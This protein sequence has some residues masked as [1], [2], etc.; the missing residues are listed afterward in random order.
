M[1]YQ[2]ATT[3]RNTLPSYLTTNQ[4]FDNTVIV[5]VPGQTNSPL[6]MNQQMD[7]SLGSDNY[8]CFLGLPTEITEQ[9][10]LD[11][12]RAQKYELPIEVEEVHE[13]VMTYLRL[14]FKSEQTVRDLVFQDVYVGPT[15][16]NLIFPVLVLPLVGDKKVDE[17]LVHHQVQVESSIPVDALF[18]GL[19][20]DPYGMMVDCIDMKP[21]R[22]V[23][24]FSKQR[25][26][27]RVLAIPNISLQKGDIEI[28]M[29]HRL[30]D[31]CYP[32]LR[33]NL[34]SQ[35]QS[36]LSRYIKDIY[37]EN[38]SLSPNKEQPAAKS[39]EFIE[40]VKEAEEAAITL[41]QPVSE[42]NDSIAGKRYDKNKGA[43]N[44]LFHMRWR[45]LNFVNRTTI[46]RKAYL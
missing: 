3:H 35:L 46:T 4:R 7:A 39:K 16:E 17:L 13:G 41:T 2:S 28:V 19:F 9:Q 42:R 38:N 10:V 23:L 29:Q 6:I 36:I 14:G 8:C 26:A 21:T 1:N 37:S 31:H 27:E 24:I 44:N 11:S 40:E 33:K 45:F 20:Y 12:L 30:V 22:H 18:L 15:T 32:L 25:Y 34:E 5:P 43:G